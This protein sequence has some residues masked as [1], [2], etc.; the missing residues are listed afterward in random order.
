LENAPAILNRC[1]NCTGRLGAV[2]DSFVWADR[3][4]CEPCYRRLR[5]AKGIQYSPIWM[6]VAL[7][8][9]TCVAALGIVVAAL[10][11]KDAAFQ[12]HPPRLA[13]EPA[14][15]TRP[16]VDAQ[17]PATAEP[18]VASQPPV[19]AALAAAGTRAA[20]TEPSAVPERENAARLL[21]PPAAGATAG[22]PTLTSAFY[23]QGDRFVDVSDVVARHLDGGTKVIAS[24][25]PLELTRDPVPNTR[26]VLRLQLAVGGQMLVLSV[27]EDGTV[28]LKRQGKEG[29]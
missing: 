21:A 28:Q 29:E 10:V 14:A 8:A 18:S 7:V 24:S 4:V 9:I 16:S 19:A 3:P 13:A 5:R 17:P 1:A 22:P 15:A 6:P 2:G 25:G 26:K 20:P 27:P 11:A 23:G 12:G